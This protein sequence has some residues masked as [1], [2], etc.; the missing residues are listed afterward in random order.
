[1][2]TLGF[3]AKLHSHWC[4]PRSPTCTRLQGA[5]V[6]EP[7]R[8][9]ASATRSNV[10][11]PPGPF[12]P[13]RKS[14]EQSTI[15]IHKQIALRDSGN[16]VETPVREAEAGHSP[17]RALAAERD[18]HSPVKPGEGG[19]AERGQG[20]TDPMHAKPAAVKVFFLCL[21]LAHLTDEHPSLPVP[22]Y[23][24]V[25]SKQYTNSLIL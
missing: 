23:H 7:L 16:T 3:Q 18:L 25:E 14:S 2:S 8:L 15:E 22:A 13:P 20:D 24:D 19:V 5:Q 11:S 6:G 10:S 4:R 9:G 17:S 1:M 12:L 21:P